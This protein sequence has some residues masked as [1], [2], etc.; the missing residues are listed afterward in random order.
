MEDATGKI[1]IITV[2]WNGWRHTRECIHALEASDAT[3]WRLYI[4]DNASTDGS[5]EHLRDLPSNAVLIESSVN[6]GWAGGNNIAIKRAL[7][8]GCTFIFLLNNDAMVLPDTLNVL[9]RT[10]V[11]NQH[12]APVLGPVNMTE[13]GKG[14]DFVATVHNA[15]KGTP[16]RV[17]STEFARSLEALLVPTAYINGAGLFAS[18]DHFRG[19]GLFDERFFL[20]YDETDWCYRAR[21]AG[22]PL[23]TVSKAAILHKGSASIG[24]A[25]S[26]L[27]T[28][29]MTRNRLLFLE[30]HGTLGQRLLALRELVWIARDISGRQ[31]RLGWL[32]PTIAAKGGRLAAFRQGFVDYVLRRFGDCPSVVREWHRIAQEKQREG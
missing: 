21:A 16:D 9:L 30:K 8:E 26:V 6:A 7:A 23:Y 22:F 11:E 15:Q 5:Q 3:N 20:N 24:G 18:A 29:F 27:Q 10:Y 19:V 28:Y 1:G 31:S 4:V 32:A 25:S 12:S 13:D 2:N 14:Y 17:P